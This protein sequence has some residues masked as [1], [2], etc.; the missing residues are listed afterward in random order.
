[1]TSKDSRR[2][3]RLAL[4]TL[5][6][7]RRAAT[8]A[9]FAIALPV[10][11]GMS[12][13]AID[14]GA[15]MVEKRQAQGA[16]DQAAYSTAI[17]AKANPSI[18]QAQAEAEAR[19]VAANMGFVHN[20]DGV[21]VT[22]TKLTA[23]PY[24]GGNYWEVIVQQ[25]QMAGLSRIFMTSAVSA[26]A[27]A[28]AGGTSYGNGCIIAL[29]QT[30][31]VGVYFMNQA[32]ALTSTCGI[33]SNSTNN[34]TSV[35]CGQPNGGGANGNC[36]IN[37]AVYAA[38]RIGGSQG[39]HGTVVQNSSLPSGFDNPYPTVPLT[40]PSGAACT[41]SVTNLDYGSTPLASGTYCIS[42]TLR[43]SN[44]VAGVAA[45]TVTLI[46]LNGATVTQLPNVGH[47]YINAPTSGTYANIAI[48]SLGTADLNFTNGTNG[49]GTADTFHIQ[50]AIYAP[51]ANLFFTGGSQFDPTMCTQLVGATV[52][53][54]LHA[55]MG[56]NCP[57]PGA[58]ATGS[59]SISLVE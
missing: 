36:T 9:M 3:L 51:N 4:S 39:L 50:G 33:Y 46:L 27:R 43:F 15:W 20:T 49:V 2:A 44:T 32:D 5:W 48:M 47:V 24:N 57:G 31:T 42:G 37:A 17:G 16:A 28:V 58:G 35:A 10:L 8:A 23:A 1:M 29:S 7:D 6:R 38:G 40:A 53:I 21:T 56:S 18:T 19:G 34:K 52:T 14:A 45:S 54:G 30:A 11:A 41:Y 55:N 22:V 13:L 59:A 12:A 26:R 25:P